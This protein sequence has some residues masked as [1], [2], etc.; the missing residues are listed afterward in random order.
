MN[1]QHNQYEF[2]HAEGATT[3]IKGWVHGVPLE[4]KARQ[5][6]RNIATLPFVGPWVAVMPDVHLG[7][8]ATVGSVVPTAARS[9]RPRSAST[10]AAAWPQCAPR[11]APATCR[12][13]WRSCATRS[14]AACRSATA[15]AAI[16]AACRTASRRRLA[17]VGPD[18][19]ARGDPR[20]APEDPPG[21]GRPAD[22]H[23]RR[24]QPLHRALPRRGRS[25]VGDAALGFARHRQHD[26]H[27]LHRAARASN[28][29]SACS[30]STC[31]TRTSRSSSKASRCSTTTSKRC[32]GRRTTRA[33]TARR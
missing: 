5:Q 30:A 23:A 15:R 31:R 29:R 27:L 32:R 16:T 1:T 2:L 18:G 24:R 3:P 12:T 22:R 20:Q 25:R 14:S 7:I 13:T 4:D 8:G 19:A 28:W 21:Q 9:S 33:P 6:L 11:C 17:R 26:R 10:S